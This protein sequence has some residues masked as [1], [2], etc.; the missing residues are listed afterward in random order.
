MF[1]H[2]SLHTYAHMM[3]EFNLAYPI[4][5]TGGLMVSDDID[6]NSAWLDFCDSRN[7]RAI[8]LSKGTEGN[9]FAFF[10]KSGKS[11]AVD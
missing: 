7:E 4:L 6:Y 5:E 3:A 11:P 10:V 8:F 2:D 9:R 1:V